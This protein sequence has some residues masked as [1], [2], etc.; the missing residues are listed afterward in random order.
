MEKLYTIN[1]VRD[2]LGVTRTTLY[3]W[4]NSG[5]LKYV[6]VG[7]R[8]RIPQSDLDAFIKVGKREDGIKEQ[9]DEESKTPYYD[10]TELVT[11]SV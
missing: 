8:R 6:V 1:E 7:S 3:E 10:L 5:Q 11:V 2:L 4:M 9:N